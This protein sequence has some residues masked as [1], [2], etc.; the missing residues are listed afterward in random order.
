M[1]TEQFNAS[2]EDQ[3]ETCRLILVDKAKEYASDVDRLHNFR[4]A[5]NV[6]GIT[7]RQALVGMMAKHTV[8]IYDMGSSNQDFSGYLWSEKITDHINYLLLLKAV[9]DDEAFEKAYE[10]NDNA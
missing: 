5:G 6:Q 1:N 2:I 8:S 10:E 3:I 4:V 7:P 9:L